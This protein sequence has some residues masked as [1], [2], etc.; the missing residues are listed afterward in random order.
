[1]RAATEDYRSAEDVVGTFLAECT[2]REA[3]A[4]TAFKR[5]YAEYVK[6]SDENGQKPISKKRLGE[7]L[8]GR[9][10]EVAR[11]TGN[12]MQCMGIEITSEAESYARFGDD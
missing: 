6:W 8:R 9:G 5:L 4:S 2:E 10:I 7:D 12:A 11:G 3:S 1:M